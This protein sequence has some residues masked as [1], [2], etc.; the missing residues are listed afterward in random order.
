MFVVTIDNP[1]YPSVTYAETIEEAREIRDNLVDF[2]DVADGK[3]QVK[4]T[5]AEILETTEIRTHY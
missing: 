5:I 4:V 2:Y 3:H 1:N